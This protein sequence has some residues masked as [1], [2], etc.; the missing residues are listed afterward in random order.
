MKLKHFWYALLVISP[1]LAY[2]Q[3][4]T[5][6]RFTED[7]PERLETDAANVMIRGLVHDFSNKLCSRL[8]GPVAQDIH[9]EVGEW[10]KRNDLFIHGAA[11]V[12]NDFANKYIPIGGEIAKQ[13]YL[14]MVLRTTTKTASERVMRQ[15][16]GATLDNNII[17]Q[18][19]AC[20]GLARMLH[21][22][23]ADFERSP[24]TT[25]ALLVYMQRNVKP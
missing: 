21:D 13:D 25:Q 9:I 2:G 15:L 18:Q 23:L 14:Q 19:A 11:E 10:Q 6:N 24:Q 20:L 1:L 17:P 12:L 4:S 3:T 16:N 8:G 22:G 5:F 7:M